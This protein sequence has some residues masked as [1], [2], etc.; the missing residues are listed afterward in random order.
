MEL[1]KEEADLPVP[2]VEIGLLKTIISN[3]EYYKKKVLE[4]PLDDPKVTQKLIQSGR[5][6]EVETSMVNIIAQRKVEWKSKDWKARV[7]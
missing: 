3:V 1:Y 7:L 2:L 6:L 4:N 5:A